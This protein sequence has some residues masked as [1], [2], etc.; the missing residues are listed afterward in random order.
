MAT[1]QA[2]LYVFLKNSSI[3]FIFG[4]LLLADPCLCMFLE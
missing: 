3:P 4:F 1:V 2:F